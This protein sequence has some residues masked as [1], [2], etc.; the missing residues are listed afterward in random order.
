MDPPDPNYEFHRNQFKEMNDSKH[1]VFLAKA[2]NKKGRSVTLLCRMDPQANGDVKLVPVARMIDREY[3][4][5]YDIAGV[6]VPFEP[7]TKAA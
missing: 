1:L 6:T 7:E 4:E 5:M 2:K 3:R